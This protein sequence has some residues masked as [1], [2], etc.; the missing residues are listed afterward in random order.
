MMLPSSLRV[1]CSFL[2]ACMSLCAFGE[3][4]ITWKPHPK[5][6][7]YVYVISKDEQ[8][9]AP[10]IES[11]TNTPES[12]DLDDLSPGPY[13]IKVKFIDRWG[14]A[15]RF[16]PTKSFEVIKEQEP[17]ESNPG[18]LTK[19]KDYLSAELSYIPNLTLNYDG[20]DFSKKSFLSSSVSKTVPS[21]LIDWT[22]TLGGIATTSD[23]SKILYASLGV[24]QTTWSEKIQYGLRSTLQF[25][26]ISENSTK[27]SLDISGSV[28][29]LGPTLALKPVH[30]LGVDSH[31]GIDKDFSKLISLKLTSIELNFNFFTL[32]PGIGYTRTEVLGAAGRLEIEAFNFLI[33]IKEAN[34]TVSN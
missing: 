18:H 30:Y 33:T 32:S 20:K 29:S 19:S 13:Y 23:D 12:R 2:A 15:S 8:F 9:S 1:A 17:S 24:H 27:E 31:L 11:E 3:S 16:S 7:S 10:L 26:N 5:A 25:Y 4:T 14:R 21:S 22:G 28:F 34:G 6:V